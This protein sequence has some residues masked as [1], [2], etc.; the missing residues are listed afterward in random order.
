MMHYHVSTVAQNGQTK[1]LAQIQLFIPSFDRFKCNAFLYIFYFLIRSAVWFT[2]A[3]FNHT[4]NTNNNNNNDS[5][6]IQEIIVLVS[7]DIKIRNRIITE[8]SG[9][10]HLYSECCILGPVPVVEN[11]LPQPSV[12]FPEHTSFSSDI[13]LLLYPS[14]SLPHSSLLPPLSPTYF[15]H[16]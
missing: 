12:L 10:V 2:T 4:H 3:S 16:F 6:N 5:N 8:K 15:P 13:Y 9:S 7:V 14:P 11:T 1:T